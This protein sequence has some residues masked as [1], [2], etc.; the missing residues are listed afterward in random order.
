MRHNL[1]TIV[2]FLLITSSSSGQDAL[3][4][5]DSLDANSSLHGRSNALNDLPLGTRNSEIRRN[6]ILRGRSFDNDIGRFASDELMFITDAMNKGGD[7]AYLEALY[8][9]PWYWN[10]WDQQSAQFLSQGDISFFNP[11][12]VDDWSESSRQMHTGRNIRSYAHEWDAETARQYSG[13]AEEE[14]P[15]NWS[16]RQVEQYK[17]GQALGSG[18][19]TPSSDTSPI[20]IGIYKDQQSIG[21]LSASPLSGVTLELGQNPVSALGFTA[22]DAARVA[23]DKTD[24]NSD[25]T[26]LIQAWRTEENRLD[27]GA[28]DHRAMVSDQYNSV[29]ETIANK[30]LNETADDGGVD[31]TAEWLDEQYA[32][33]QTQLTG[34]PYLA[35][36]PE[37]EIL[38]EEVAV[39]EEVVDEIGAILRH[40]ELISQFSSGHDNRFNELVRIGE[41]KLALGEYFLAEKRFNQALRFVP[42]HPLATAGLGH[43]NIGAGMYLSAAHILQSLISLQ[44]E[45]IDVKYEAQLLP[46]RLELVRAAVAIRG[47][48][49]EERDGGT[50]AFL[51]GYIGHQLNDI[52]MI[53][54][55]LNALKTRVEAKDPIVH[56][57]ESIWLVETKN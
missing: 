36:E 9:S 34:M 18:Y 7:D 33:L 31:Q 14:Y 23:E 38:I 48:I 41:Q 56:L 20:P 42:G 43:A 46:P 32:L 47:R 5:G 52:E 12:F 4:R 57:L 6:G 54:Q 45:M 16:R 44:P 29:L 50:Y 17:L 49:E 21:Y 24:P 1:T 30:T 39:E 27:Q 26:N 13:D 2:L 37:D 15:V 51:L 55:G 11:S 3:G 40:G 8:N 10:N 53:E 25:T 35:E 28:V 22:W 19:Q